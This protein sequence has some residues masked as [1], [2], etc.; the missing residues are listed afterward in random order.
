VLKAT[1][2]ALLHKSELGAVAV[3]LRD[4]EEL[5]AALAAMTTRLA[6]AGVVPDG[7]LL[8]EH[9]RGGQEVIFG[10]SSDPRFGPLLL[11]GL[12]GKYVEVLDDV[13]VALPPLT[14]GDA[15]RLVRSIRS[16]RLLLGVRG[17]VLEEVLL[18]LAQ[19]VTRHPRIEELDLNP[20]L[21]A[22]AGGSPAA[23]DVRVRIG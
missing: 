20:F 18:R 5:A 12:G 13:Q 8:Q 14:R 9:R 21:A 10:V 7:F 23:L 1:G 22:P 19:L 16:V 17:E 4:A 11:F 6:A 3:D 15:A 2:A